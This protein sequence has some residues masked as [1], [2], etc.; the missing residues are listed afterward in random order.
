MRLNCTRMASVV[1]VEVYYDLLVSKNTP[2]PLYC[3]CKQQFMKILKNSKI[4]KI[5]INTYLLMHV[6]KRV[7]FFLDKQY[8][9]SH[10]IVAKKEIHNYQKNKVLTGIFR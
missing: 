2:V 6:F 9:L 5:Y 10:F 3:L 8:C 7:Q 4:L 1:A